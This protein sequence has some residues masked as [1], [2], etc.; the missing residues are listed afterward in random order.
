M[1]NTFIF[2]LVTIILPVIL[3]P[4]YRYLEIISTVLAVILQAEGS[5]RVVCLPHTT[6]Q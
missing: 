4:D 3:S 5:E 1:F 2:I 6:A